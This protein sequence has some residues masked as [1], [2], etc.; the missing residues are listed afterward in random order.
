MKCKAAVSGLSDETISMLNSAR[1]SILEKV[2]VLHLH[3]LKNFGSS[4]FY[5]QRCDIAD[6]ST[7][8]PFCEVRLSGVSTSDNRSVNDFIRAR[9][10][11]EDEY[12]RLIELSRSSSL[13][14]VEVTAIIML[15]KPSTPGGSTLVEG[16]PVKVRGA[17]H[18]FALPLYE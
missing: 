10:A 7:H 5:V 17:V 16:P 1:P 2:L 18:S 12:K 15:D 8:E 11:L 4:E 3:V 6:D 13:P 9:Q 14:M